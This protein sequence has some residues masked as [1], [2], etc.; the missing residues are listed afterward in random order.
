MAFFISINVLDLLANWLSDQ[1][2]KQILNGKGH[3]L[4][5]FNSYEFMFVFFAIGSFGILQVV[6][7]SG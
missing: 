1:I 7:G 5:L 3:I 6:P 2:Y 4:M